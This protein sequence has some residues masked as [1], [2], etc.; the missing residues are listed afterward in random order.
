MVPAYNEGDGVKLTLATIDELAEVRL[1]CMRAHERVLGGFAL[2][3]G[4]FLSG[5]MSYSPPTPVGPLEEKIVLQK[6]ERRVRLPRK[7]GCIC[8]MPTIQQTKISG[9]MLLPRHA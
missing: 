4:Y 9:F 1:A 8:V 5:E 3:M 2:G 6:R 7:T